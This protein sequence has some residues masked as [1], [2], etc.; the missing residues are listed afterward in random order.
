VQLGSVDFDPQATLEHAGLDKDAVKNV[1]E[2]IAIMTGM[3]T[4]VMESHLADIWVRMM[5]T[6]NAEFP[7]LDASRVRGQNHRS[8]RS[9]LESKASQALIKDLNVIAD[10]LQ[11]FMRAQESLFGSNASWGFWS[12]HPAKDVAAKGADVTLEKSALGAIFEGYSKPLDIHYAEL[13]SAVSR[14]YVR[15]AARDFKNRKFRAF[16]GNIQDRSVWNQVEQPLFQQ[17]AEEASEPPDITFYACAGMPTGNGYYDADFTKSSGGCSGAFT[18]AAGLSAREPIQQKAADFFEA[19]IV[20]RDPEMAEI[21]DPLK[22]KKDSLL[23]NIE[24]MKTLDPT[25]NDWA[26]FAGFAASKFDELCGPDK[27]LVTHG[28]TKRAL[29]E[30]ADTAFAV[31]RELDFADLTDPTALKNRATSYQEAVPRWKTLIGK[32]SNC[33]ERQVQKFSSRVDS[34]EAGAQVALDGLAIYDHGDRSARSWY[35]EKIPALYTA[36]TSLWSLFRDDLS[37]D[38]RPLWDTI[39]AEAEEAL[40]ASEQYV[41][42]HKDTDNCTDNLWARSGVATLDHIKDERVGWLELARYTAL[43]ERGGRAVFANVLERIYQANEVL[44]IQGEF[45]DLY[46]TLPPDVKEADLSKKKEV[47]GELEKLVK[48]HFGG[49]SRMIG[50]LMVDLKSEYRTRDE[51]LAKIQEYV[52]GF[53]AGFGDASPGGLTQ[54]YTRMLD[55]VIGDEDNPLAAGE[56][57]DKWIVTTAKAGRLGGIWT[58]FALGVPFV[59]PVLAGLGRF[60]ASWASKGNKLR[61]LYDAGAEWAFLQALQAGLFLLANPVAGAIVGLTG[62]VMASLGLIGGTVTRQLTDGGTDTVEKLERFCTDI[63]EQDFKTPTIIA[64]ILAYLAQPDPEK[65][66]S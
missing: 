64:D 50:N 51:L 57:E 20:G 54:L 25:S 44:D 26:T 34:I 13:W 41:A 65:T 49:W 9:D 38:F 23:T 6:L 8:G 46:I 53:L 39:F 2:P 3:S 45:D 5:T 15:R 35:A 14:A 17:L 22:P 63:H 40:R 21:E 16:A 31:I 61:A 19:I 18:S 59:G 66:S 29:D 11:L 52:G 7:R 27:T 33:N 56:S 32:M 4:S 1:Y 12:G 30:V 43:G 24:Q 42:L 37:R 62:A 10:D 58:G 55:Q 36:R 48:G 60:F 28:R 47:K